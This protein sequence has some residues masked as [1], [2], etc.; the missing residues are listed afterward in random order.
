MKKTRTTL[1]KIEAL[2][3][4]CIAGAV[5]SL[6]VNFLVYRAT[7]SVVQT[8]G[9]DTAPSIITADHINALLADA[10]SN[11]MNAMVTKEKSGGKFWTL[12]RKDMLEL[13][14]ELI[15]ISENITFGDDER[16]A[17]LAIMSNVSAY[18]YTLGGAVSNG[19]EISVDQFGEANR[20]MQQKI[21]PS[22]VKL[23]DIYST[24]LDA[25][26]NRFTKSIN[27]VLAIMIV[28]ALTVLV[29]LLGTQYFLFKKTH[30]IF[31]LG[32]LLATILF[33]A[34]IIYSANTMNSVKSNLY[35]AKHDAFD[36]VQALWGARATAYNANALESLYLLHNGT[37]IV[38]TADTINFNLSSAKLCADPNA[39]LNGSKFE[40]YLGEEINNVTFDGE[41]AAATAAIQEWSKYVDVDKKIRNLEYDSKHSEAVALCVGESDGQSNYE[42]SKFDAEL[43]K[44]I[45]INQASFGSNMNRAYKTLNIF[46][47]ATA[48]F[49]LVIIVLCVF[50][51]RPR[52]EEYKA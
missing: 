28:I 31:N 43:G 23:K 38:Q 42:F 25:S 33:I 41:K 48:I 52:I 36:S 21:L 1:G 24:Y 47:Y 26:Y 16:N 34:N 20:L 18:E 3:M 32:L 30:R 44:A 46:P 39:A 8:V 13:H 22:S 19:A 49:L 15:N 12:Y 40:G 14:S 7:H 11:A 9:K 27:I 51:F 45:E 2:L 10:H 37:G 5:I 4:V 29:I 6:S 35:S 50:G 17:I